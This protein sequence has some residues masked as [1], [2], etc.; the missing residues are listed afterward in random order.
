[1][2]AS[3]LDK[4]L[5]IHV[6]K[7]D[8]RGVEKTLQ[9]GACI[10]G[11]DAHRPLHV[12][13]SFGRADVIAVLAARGAD[14][15][16]SVPGDVRDG[17]G[18]FVFSRGSRAI[19][20]AVYARMPDAIHALTAAGANPNAADATG[21]TP[22]MQACRSLDTK[23]RIAMVRELLTA[24]ADPALQSDDG[25][26][27]LHFAALRDGADVIELLVRRQRAT[28]D[29]STGYAG[30]PL[31]C[32]ASAGFEKAVSCLMS[33]GASDRALW[34]EKGASA[35][36]GA[37]QE[38]REGVVSILLGADSI[39][40][41]GG[42]AAVSKAI[43]TAVRKR[44]ARM[45]HMLLATAE[46]EK[47]QELWARQR[48]S[49]T[50]LLSQAAEA[51]S[52]AVVNVL[53]RAGAQEN[54]GGPGNRPSECIRFTGR[55]NPPQEAAIVRMLRRGPAY[56]ARPR[57]WPTGAGASGRAAKPPLDVRIFWPQGRRF[58]ATRFNR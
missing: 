33:L 50:P 17:E 31:C 37:V 36:I 16:A 26:V 8:V 11:F 47:Q 23:E 55:I 9:L 32:A 28:L 2:S 40:T 3:L 19:H 41:V 27:A 57:A 18:R 58:F 1:M 49:D 46:G 34:S 56:R 53:L 29:Q 12:A 13:A 44:E 14:L 10:D 43:R 5:H 54:E 35:L 20:A 15:E 45:L 51:G 25:M 21:H 7:G 6:R 22:L 30:T 4:Q 52:L 24:G 48:S 42:A 38:G 39:D